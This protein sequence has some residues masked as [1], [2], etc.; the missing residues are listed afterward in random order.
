MKRRLFNIVS[1]FSL[2]LAVALA[3]MWVRSYWWWDVVIKPTG[4]SLS[5]VA[6]EDG[7]ISLTI[8]R[9][10][11]PS[12]GKHNWIFH[13]RHTYS[14]RQP[15]S[16]LWRFELQT[17]HLTGDVRGINFGGPITY[18]GPADFY[19]V[20]PVWLPLLL[21]CIM[22]AFWWRKHRKFRRIERVRLRLCPTC[23]YDV[24]GSAG[25]CPECGANLAIAI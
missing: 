14:F 20:F 3:A 6:L 15:Y 16:N 5:G 23:G 2:V 19:V 9:E 1:A 21:V 10:W 22:P 7:E 12:L 25:K 4:Y 11:T 17:L 24:R 18:G 8:D 13:T